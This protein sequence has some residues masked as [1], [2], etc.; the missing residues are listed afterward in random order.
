MGSM[1]QKVLPLRGSLSK[2][3]VPPVNAGGSKN[4]TLNYADDSVGSTNP[5]MYFHMPNV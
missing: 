4:G 5:C 2:P 1:N 3:I